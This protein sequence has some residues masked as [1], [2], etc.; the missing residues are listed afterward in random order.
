MK[1]IHCTRCG[2]EISTHARRCPSCFAVNDSYYELLP[3]VLADTHRAEYDFMCDVESELNYHIDEGGELI[4]YNQ[5]MRVLVIPDKVKMFKMGAFPDDHYGEIY[6]PG[7]NGFFEDNQNIEIVY[8]PGNVIEIPTRAFQCCKNLKK[9]VIENGVERIGHNAFAGCLSLEEITFPPSVSQIGMTAFAGCSSLTVVN[10]GSGISA[11]GAMAFSG[12]NNLESLSISESEE[13][14]LLYDEGHRRSGRDSTVFSDCPMIIGKRKVLGSLLGTVFSEEEPF[15]QTTKI[16]II[17]RK[18]PAHGLGQIIGAYRN[19]N[20]IQVVV[21]FAE[22]TLLKLKRNKYTYWG[23]ECFCDEN[24]ISPDFPLDVV[25]ELIT[26]NLGTSISNESLDAKLSEFELQRISILSKQRGRAVYRGY[27]K[28]CFAP[29]NSVDNQLCDICE[30]EYVCNNCGYCGHCH[31]SHLEDP[32]IRDARIYSRLSEEE[33]NEKLKECEE[34]YLQE[35]G[36]EEY[37]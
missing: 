13:P 29:I 17:S 8:I 23:I 32:A 7:E 28:E 34:I 30:S 11:I 15:F 26:A 18:L 27:C 20:G 24:L 16:P 22:S 10:I 37:E 6:T 12:C 1:S 19:E 2:K 4:W 3:S 14:L 5:N 36:I 25:R 31:S 9:V 35:I 33:W 21:E